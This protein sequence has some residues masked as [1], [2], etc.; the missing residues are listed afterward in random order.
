MEGIERGSIGMK[1]GPGMS[2]EEIRMIKKAREFAAKAHEGQ[3]RKGTDRPYI[4]HPIDAFPMPSSKTNK[5][6]NSSFSCCDYLRVP[7]LGF[8][9]RYFMISV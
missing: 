7:L 5:I 4:V 8:N 2:E 1:R 3:F 6:V 9:R